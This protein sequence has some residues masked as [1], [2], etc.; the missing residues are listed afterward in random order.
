[1][2]QVLQVDVEE[3]LNLLRVFQ[4][5]QVSLLVEVLQTQILFSEEEE[6]ELEGSLLRVLLLAKVQHEELLQQPAYHQ[7]HL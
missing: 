6:T 2:V 3:G 7:L 1:L 4:S 5:A